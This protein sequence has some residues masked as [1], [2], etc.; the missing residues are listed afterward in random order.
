SLA[1]QQRVLGMSK[2][3]TQVLH[4]TSTPLLRRQEAAS[5][6]ARWTNP[7]G[8]TA[9]PGGAT[10]GA[11]TPTTAA[12]HTRARAGATAKS[13]ATAKPG[14]Q[15]GGKSSSGKAGQRSTTDTVKPRN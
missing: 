10:G 9:A 6:P 13:G 2:W 15:S 14:S 7:C 1:C 3:Y 12:A 8:Q 4:P 5:L 11:V